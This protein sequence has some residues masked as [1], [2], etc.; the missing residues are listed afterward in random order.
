MIAAKM[1]RRVRT[2][3]NLSDAYL[4]ALSEPVTLPPPYDLWTTNR[5]IVSRCSQDI[6]LEQRTVIVWQ[7][8][9]NGQWLGFP[10]L[11]QFK[12]D[13]IEEAIRMAGWAIQGELEL[14]ETGTAGE[15]R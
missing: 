9:D 14:E 11:H 15:Y 6:P 10:W 13:S 7:S 3:I 8:N 5:V 2:S 1:M 4:F 12:T